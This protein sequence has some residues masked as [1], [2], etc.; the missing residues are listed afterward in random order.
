MRRGKA[1]ALH[2]GREAVGVTLLEA[3]GKLFVSGVSGWVGGVRHC[4]PF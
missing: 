2:E 1:V 4:P 3:E